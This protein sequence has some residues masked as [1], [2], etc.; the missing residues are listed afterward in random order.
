[1]ANELIG[2]IDDMLG[3]AKMSGRMIHN[4]YTTYALLK[5]NWRM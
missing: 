2:I 4:K 1:M 5:H 3:Y